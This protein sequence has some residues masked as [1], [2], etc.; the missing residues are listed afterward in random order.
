MAMEKTV[1]S[2]IPPRGPKPQAP[3]QQQQQ[4]QQQQS[5][6]N[7]WRQSRATSSGY[8]RPGK[9]RPDLSMAGCTSPLHM[10]IERIRSREQK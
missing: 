9:V 7:V 3:K 4:Q 1:M 2:N 5:R 6:S 8:T 10:L